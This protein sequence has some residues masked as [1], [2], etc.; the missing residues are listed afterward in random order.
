[1]GK[2]AMHRIQNSPPKFVFPLSALAHF[3][4][5]FFEKKNY[6]LSFPPA[7]QIT[8]HLTVIK[9]T[10]PHYVELFSGV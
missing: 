3:K 10:N 1:M 2:N 5:N 4:S 9:T 8:A 7:D 6:V